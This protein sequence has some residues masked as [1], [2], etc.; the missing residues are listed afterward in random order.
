MEEELKKYILSLFVDDSGNEKIIY[1]ADIYHSVL[2][3]YKARGKTI[4]FEDFLKLL[5]ELANEGLIEKLDGDKYKISDKG[6]QLLG[7]VFRVLIEFYN[8]HS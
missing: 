4:S 7:R 1:P 5:E 8:G 2:E 6:K 3:R